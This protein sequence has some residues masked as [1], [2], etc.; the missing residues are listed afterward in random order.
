MGDNKSREGL[1]KVFSLWDPEGLGIIDFDSFKRIA[2]ELGETM[3][4]DDLTEMMHNAYILNNTETHENFSFEEF[5]NIVTKKRA[6]LNPNSIKIF[7]F[8]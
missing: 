6:W 3:N 2:K 1:K 4:D 8:F 5:Y 7:I